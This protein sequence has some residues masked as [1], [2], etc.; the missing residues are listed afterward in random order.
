MIINSC[1]S[2]F[3]GCRA[4][5]AGLRNRAASAKAAVF[6]VMAEHTCIPP[7]TA[8]RY[9]R[10]LIITKC[11]CHVCVCVSDDPNRLMIVRSTVSNLAAN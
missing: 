1:D 6:L 8:I 4:C 11:V 5:G 9:D 10:A 3:A 2:R 7:R